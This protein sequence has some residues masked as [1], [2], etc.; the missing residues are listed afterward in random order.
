MSGFGKS[1]HIS[2]RANKSYNFA[3]SPYEP[4]INYIL[5][6]IVCYIY[7]RSLIIRTP[8]CHFNVKGV[9]INEIVRIS[10]LSNKNTLFS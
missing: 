10:E 3:P 7:S 4:E 5:L 8:V 9:Q 2:L 6:T 1:G